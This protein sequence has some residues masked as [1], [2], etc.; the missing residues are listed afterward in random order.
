M[1]RA[2]ARLV[3]ARLGQAALALFG[4]SL[5]IWG[6]MPLTPGDPAERTLLARGRGIPPTAEEVAFLRAE[7][8]L[9][10]P[11]YVQY[12]VWANN[13]L[14]GKLGYSYVSGQPVER[15][16]YQRMGATMLLA[17]GAVAIALCVSFPAAV[18]SA[19]WA[20]GAPDHFIRV[21]AL[22]GRSMPSF[23]L[24]LLLLDLF[25]VRLRWTSVLAKPDIGGLPLPALTLSV[26]MAAMLTRLLRAGI[27]DEMGRRYTLVARARGAGD[28]HV[29][30]CHALPNGALPSINA[31][32]LGVGGLLGGAAIVETIFTWPGMGLYI[33]QAIGARDLPVIQ[34]FAI[35]SAAIYIAVNLLADLITLTLDPRLRV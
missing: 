20:N 8:G 29:L 13:L 26:G 25:A 4:M 35:M 7:L 3:M 21:V 32:A 23:W 5:L 16:F 14:H 6:L 31:I 1:S 28:W 18:A 12:G 27:L 15:E 34:A 10:Q 17:A 30:L 2:I 11:L 9:D 33:V 24:G 19:R 22:A